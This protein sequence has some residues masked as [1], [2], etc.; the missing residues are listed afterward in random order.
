MIWQNIIKFP[1]A[2]KISLKVWVWFNSLSAIAAVRKFY[3]SSF[4]FS[5]VT[6]SC[7]G[8]GALPCSLLGYIYNWTLSTVSSATQLHGL[9]WQLLCTDFNTCQLWDS[10]Y[11]INVQQWVGADTKVA[12]KSLWMEWKSS[13][14]DQRGP[15][16]SNSSRQYRAQCVESLTWEHRYV[17]TC[18]IY[19]G[20]GT[21]QTYRAAEVIY[22]WYYRCVRQT[23][24]SPNLLTF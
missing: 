17:Y 24:F 23:C 10:L 14:R 12:P 1:L 6:R 2:S 18:N 7:Q 3:S 4:S 20:C 13:K 9:L 16:K 8:L 22:N 19:K 5:L 21:N 15:L 11:V